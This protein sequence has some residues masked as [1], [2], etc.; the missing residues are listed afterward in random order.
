MRIVSGSAR[1]R[2]LKAPPNNARTRP[3]ADKIKEALF[4]SLASFGVKPERVLDLYA[5]SGGVGIE[6]LSRGADWCDF[7]DQDRIAVQTIRENL[8]NTGFPQLGAVHHTSIQ[9]FVS[10]VREPYDFVILDPP[11]ADPAILDTLEWLSRSP[12][13][14]DGTI[15][16]LGH[17]PRLELPDEIG[18]LSKLRG[19]CHG[20]SCFAIF[21]TVIPGAESDVD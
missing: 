8:Q 9:A 12:A 18:Q 5:G 6:A 20:D 7:V 16:V 4:S 19:R 21:D 3:M 1:G 14:V 15:V 11:Y 13:V 17:W 2:R 10:G